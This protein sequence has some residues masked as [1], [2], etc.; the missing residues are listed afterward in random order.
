MPHRAF[1]HLQ[2][3]CPKLGGT[4]DFGYCRT[5]QQGLPCERALGCFEFSFPVEEYF[6]RVLREETFQRCFDSPAP[7]R[8]GS[9]L[10]HVTAAQQRLRERNE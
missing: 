1:D 6:R 10:S 4:V 9:V 5:V 3:R 8:Y 7:D 2:V